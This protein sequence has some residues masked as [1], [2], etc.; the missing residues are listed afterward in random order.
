MSF[1]STLSIDG[2]KELKLLHCSYTLQRDVDQFGRPSSDVYGG[3]ITCEI[4]AT[5]DESLFEW[6]TTSH[7]LKNGS[8]KF[9]KRDEDAKM[10]ELKWTDGY[11]IHFN[12][13]FDTTGTNPMTVSFT[14]S[15]RMIEVGS[16]AFEVEWPD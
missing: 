2:G 9:F 1:K 7:K 6:V 14:V 8:I 16:A 15:A 5:S 4:E 10:K 12:E 3:Q 11:C 13:S